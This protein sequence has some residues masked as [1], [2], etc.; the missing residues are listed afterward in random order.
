M[1]RAARP[2]RT[3]AARVTALML[4]VGVSVSAC[5][6]TL[7]GAEAGPGSLPTGI[8]DAHARHSGTAAADHD[9]PDDGAEDGHEHDDAAPADA[10]TTGPPRPADPALL[11][12]TTVLPDGEQ[13]TRYCDEG[14]AT[15]VVGDDKDTEV[16][17]AECE[18]RGA[19]FLAHFGSNYSDQTTARGDYLGLAL[20]AMPETDGPASIYALELTVDGHRPAVSAATVDVTRTGDV[21]TFDLVGELADGRTLSVGASCHTHED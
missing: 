5:T 4:A 7:A 17:G 2:S 13:V 3:G 14:L 8:H 15:F 10:A 11:C 12:G 9:H 21:V 16:K 1:T 20:E 6:G 18:D 19:L